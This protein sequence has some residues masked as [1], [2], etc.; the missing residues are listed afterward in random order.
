[1]ELLASFVIK[2][3]KP[4]KQLPW[5]LNLLISE[6]KKSCSSKYCSNSGKI[7]TLLIYC[8]VVGMGINFVT[9][10]SLSF[11]WLAVS[12][13]SGP[14]GLLL[15]VPWFLWLLDSGDSSQ[16]SN[17]QREIPSA[18]EPNLHCWGLQQEEYPMYRQLLKRKISLS[19]RSDALRDTF[20][21]S[22]V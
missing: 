12:W 3:K 20:C 1:M 18:Q 5:Q 22:H 9:V 21:G 10:R 17:H 15:W 7:S 19:R 11:L 8:W 14:Q 13:D 6:E 2:A 16:V 4:S